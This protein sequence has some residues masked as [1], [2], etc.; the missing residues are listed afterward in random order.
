MYK[1]KY[2]Y[3]YIQVVPKTYADVAKERKASISVFEQ[4]KLNLTMVMAQYKGANL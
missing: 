2:I 1:Y 4:V 3:I